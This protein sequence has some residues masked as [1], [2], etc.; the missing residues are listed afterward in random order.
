MKFSNP[1][2]EHKEVLPGIG[3]ILHKFWPQIRKRRLLISGSFLALLVE[4]GLQLLEPWPLKFIFD[5]VLVPQINVNSSEFDLVSGLNPLVLLTFLALAI[6]VITALRSVASYLSTY[7]IALAA[8]QIL[9]EVRANLYSHLQRLSLS[10]HNQFRSG[11]LIASVTYDIE[12]LRIAVIK[13]ALPLFTNILMLVGMLAIIF[14]LNWELALIALTVFPLFAFFTQRMISRIRSVA[15]KHRKTQGAIANT[16]N[17]T[18]SAIKVVQVFFLHNQ[19]ES[20]FCQ[21][22]SK[23]L[24]QGAESLKLTALL[25]GTVKVLIALVMALV[26]WRGSQLVLQKALTPGDLL[27]F[28]DY[29]KNAFGPI[30]Q[31]T[32]QIGQIAKATASGERVLDVLEYE[33]HVRDLPG[34]KKAHPFFGTVQFENVTFGYEHNRDTLTNLNFKVQPGQQVAL[35]GPS[36]SG[37][38][39]LVSLILRL[40]DPVEGRILIDGEDIRSYKLDSLRQ[41]TAVVLQESFLFAA[42]VR[43][44]IAYGKLGASNQEVEAAARLAN[45]HDFIIDLPDGY[46]TI[47]AEGGSNLSGGQRQRIAIARAAIRQAPIV[48]LDEPTTGLDSASQRVVNKAFE[49]LT[50]GKTTFII[51]HDLRAVENADVILYLERG[52]ILESG[53]HNEL[54]YL[55]GHYSTLYRLQT[56]VGKSG[57][58]I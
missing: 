16:T 4:T 24:A 39:T 44:N 5:L 47:L 32:K 2:K 31:L 55:G 48:I 8:I 51:S 9:T 21:Q 45:A 34:A 37:K 22:N 58:E 52:R 40:Y 49:R 13:I 20:D 14:W 56:T 42:S 46:E 43:E 23:S 27:V 38:S 54:M 30:R 33:H 10:F 28:I 25:Q 29:L 15:R 18:I 6:V 12:R 11:D 36:G 19:L 57:V 7:G 35:V 17:E 3:R 53:T 41:Q 1:K 26:L 50:Q